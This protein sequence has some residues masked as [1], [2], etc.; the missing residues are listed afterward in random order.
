MADF[1]KGPSNGDHQLADRTNGEI[2]E[3]SG[4]R[5]DVVVKVGLVGDAQ[6]H[7]IAV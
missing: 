5:D 6:V 1:E 2:A 7:P 3:V 4:T